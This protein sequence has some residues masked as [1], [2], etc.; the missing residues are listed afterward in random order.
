MFQNLYAIY[1]TYNRHKPKT[2]STTY[3]KYEGLNSCL[4]QNKLCNNGNVAIKDLT[5][6]KQKTINSDDM[7]ISETRQ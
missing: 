6:D 3:I 1:Q 4:F 7:N 2:T 5:H